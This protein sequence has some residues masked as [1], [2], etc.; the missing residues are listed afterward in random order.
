MTQEHHTNMEAKEIKN[1]K[2]ENQDDGQLE[3]AINELT[4]F[5]SLVQ[6]S[7][8][9]VATSSAPTD[10]PRTPLDYFRLYN[11]AG[12]RRLYVYDKASNTWHFSTLS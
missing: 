1:D 6:T 9:M 7:R 10:I 3:M 8:F 12:T 4:P 5:N 11:N 2:I